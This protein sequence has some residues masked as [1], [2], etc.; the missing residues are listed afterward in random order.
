[1]K[2][3]ALWR[4]ILVQ[5]YISVFYSV[6]KMGQIINGYKIRFY[7]LIGDSIWIKI[8]CTSAENEL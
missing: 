7:Q 2:I 3:E 1:M 6:V 4:I 5:K 8:D